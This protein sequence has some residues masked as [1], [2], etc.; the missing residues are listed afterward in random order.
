MINERSGVFICPIFIHIVSWAHRAISGDLHHPHVDPHD[1][2]SAAA[3]GGAFLAK[4]GRLLYR[5]EQLQEFEAA[6]LIVREGRSVFRLADVRTDCRSR[7]AR[8]ELSVG[9]SL[10]A[11]HTT[12]AEIFGFGILADACCTSRPRP[13]NRSGHRQESKSTRCPCGHPQSGLPD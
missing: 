4:Q 1:I 12:A 2:P 13:R 7:L 9:R 3:Q 5:W 10:I 8:A 11:C 6:G